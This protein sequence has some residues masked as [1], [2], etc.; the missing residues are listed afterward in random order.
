MPFEARSVPPIKLPTDFSEFGTERSKEVIDVAGC[1][2]CKV[3]RQVQEVL[4]EALRSSQ[5]LLVDHWQSQDHVLRSKLSQLHNIDENNVFLTAGALGAVDYSF[6]IFVREGTKVGLLSPDFSGFVHHAQRRNADIHTLKNE[7]F[8]HGQS[9]DDLHRFVSDE[10]LDFL[11]TSNPSAALGT[12]RPAEEIQELVSSHP[13]TLFVIDEADAIDT[14]SVS[15]LTNEHENLM[16]LRSFSKF[17]GLSGLRVGYM[18]CP[19]SMREHLKNTINPI[20]LTSVGILAA[21]EVLKDEEYLRATQ[22]RVSANLSMLTEACEGTPFK[23]VPGSTCF[24]AYITSDDDA[25]DPFEYLKSHNIAIAPAQTFGL[26]RGGRI[27]LSDSDN[28][29]K[30]A[31]AIQKLRTA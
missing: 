7:Q 5:A 29:Q 21:T 12:R 3:S 28:I 8:P 23:L 6:Q 1:E 14:D 10:E 11:I 27:N 31:D 13:Q 9:L 20:E 30:V 24:A 4:S 19:Q 2:N 15:S 26:N 25:K 22:Q 18:V 17:Y 16:I